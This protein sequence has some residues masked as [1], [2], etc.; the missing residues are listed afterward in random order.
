VSAQR[1]VSIAVADDSNSYLR[2]NPTDERASENSGEL[3][4]TFDNS[5]NGAGGLN[6]NSRTTFTDLFTIQNQGDN[7]VYVG[8]GTEESD[9]YI[10]TAQSNSQAH[11]A[12]YSNLSTFVY[13]EE[14]ANGVGLSFNG[15]NG[16]MGIDSGGRVDVRFNSNGSPDPASNPRILTAGES[17]NVDLDFIVDG[18]SLGSGG[19]DR[20]TVAAAEPG[21]DR[22]FTNNPG[23]YGNP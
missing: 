18:T 12:D 20:I 8:V 15:G 17:L 23:D 16:N 1:S 7:P 11:V 19:G 9:V 2:L 4:L 3:Q 10:D 6:P 14:N 5:S 22:D 13:A 21:S